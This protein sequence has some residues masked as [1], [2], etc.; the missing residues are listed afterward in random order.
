MAATS[1]LF[2]NPGGW[3]DTQDG[4]EEVRFGKAVFTG[5]NGVALDGGGFRIANLAPPVQSLDAVTKS[6]VDS[7]ASGVDWKTSVRVATTGPVLN[8]NAVNVSSIDGVTLKLG[9]RV[10][11]KNGASADGYETVNNLRNGLYVVSNIVLPNASLLR[12]TDGGSANLSSGSAVFVEEGTVNKD[13]GWVITTDNP[14]VVD[15]TEM[16]WTQFTGLGQISAGL[17]LGKLANDIFIN[18]GD[19]V[20]VAND[21]VDI[22]LAPTPGLELVGVSPSRQLAVLTSPTGGLQ[23]VASGVSVKLNGSTLAAGLDGLSVVG[24]P[25]AGVWQIGGVATALT[26]TAP[27]LATLTA[28]A[29]SNADTLHS[30]SSVPTTKGISE[31]FMLTTGAVTEVG[32]ALY[33]TTADQLAVGN[34]DSRTR[35]NIIGLATSAVTGPYPVTVISAGIFPNCLTNAVPGRAYFM[36]PNGTPVL[37]SALTP[38]SRAV[39]LGYAKNSTDLYVQIQDLGVKP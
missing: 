37:A 38:R 6:Y 14:I 5:V 3:L 36:G 10:L 24:V 11:V 8:L 20:T 23:V 15:S 33:F 31:T 25:Q 7:L 21:R 17:G 30:H 34:S 12:A 35:D 9:D 4:T 29:S 28:G 39:R 18:R 13:T 1:L 32:A 26:V 27:N 2:H 22:D 16:A 19:G